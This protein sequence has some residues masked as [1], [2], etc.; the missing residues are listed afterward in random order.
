MKNKIL[1][2]LTFIVLIVSVNAQ[3]SITGSVLDL[4]KEGVP[5]TNIYWQG[6]TI[7][8][9]AD[10]NGNFEIIEPTS[11][12]AQLIFSFVGYQTDTIKLNS[13]QKKIKV[14]TSQTQRGKT[15]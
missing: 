2:S 9:V 7:G 12:P 6:T 13:Y 11:Y 8:V 14:D 5:L 15:F 1:I 4:N 10:V 3:K